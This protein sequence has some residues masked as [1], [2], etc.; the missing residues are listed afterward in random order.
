MASDDSGFEG[1]IPDLLKAIC[2]AGHMSCDYKI[3]TA[4]DGE[5]GGRDAKGEWTG[6]IGEVE[7][8]EVRNQADTGGGGLEKGEVRNQADTGAVGWRRER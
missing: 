2:D 3:V 8:G 6:M 7:K 4:V 5:Y 1:I